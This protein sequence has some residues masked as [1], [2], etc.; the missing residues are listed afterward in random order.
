MT[1]GTFGSRIGEED[2]D[3]TRAV[4]LTGAGLG[5]EGDR[6][7]EDVSGP[8]VDLGTNGGRI[9]INTNDN[10][11]SSNNKEKPDPEVCRIQPR[12]EAGRKKKDEQP[13]ARGDPASGE[14]STYLTNED[15]T[16]NATGKRSLATDQLLC[17]T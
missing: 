4:D 16:A 3:Q 7:M 12:G 1:I 14:V 10:N 17:G 5:A 15:P 2:Q 9:N 13:T 11:G 8:T 6:H